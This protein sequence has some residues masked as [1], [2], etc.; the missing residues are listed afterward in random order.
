MTAGTGER[1]LVIDG[2]QYCNWSP[3]IFEEM[4]AGGVSCVHVTI[5]YWENLRET[6]ANISAWHGRFERHADRL[7]HVRSADDVRRAQAEGKKD[8]GGPNLWVSADWYMLKQLQHFK[9]GIRGADPR[10]A[11]GMRM[12]P[13]S[14]TLVDEQAMKDVISY[15][16]TLQR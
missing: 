15:I 6:I 8:L 13:M 14:M 2:L 9:N 12:R 11:T 5:T 16:L 3:E 7:L 1:P 4:A 10:D